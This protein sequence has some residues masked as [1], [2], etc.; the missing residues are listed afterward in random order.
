M[1]KQTTLWTALPNGYTEDRK[2]T[3]DIAAGFAAA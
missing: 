3:A 1:A 2:I